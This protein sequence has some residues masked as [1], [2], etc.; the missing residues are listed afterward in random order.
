MRLP[1]TTILTIDGVNPE[2]AARALRHSS[3][4]C[5][6]DQVKFFGYQRP[7]PSIQFDYEFIQ[8]KKFNYQ[9]YNQFVISELNS[10]IDTDFCLLIQPDGFI[11]NP[12]LWRDE[13]FQY[14]YIGALWP[15]SLFESYPQG[16]NVG[17]GGFSLRSKKFLQTVSENIKTYSFMKDFGLNKN[18]DFFLLKTNYD[19]LIDLGLKIAPPEVA[20]KFSIESLNDDFSEYIDTSQSFGF[21]GYHSYTINHIKKIIEKEEFQG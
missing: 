17:N 19:N 6:F 2:K 5:Q 7:D 1:N 8:T 9:Q 4:A 12:H 18:E 15:K 16:T 21:H 3:L 11:V 20:I 13:F 14:D 10:F